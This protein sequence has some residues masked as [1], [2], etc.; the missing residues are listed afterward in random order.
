M[1]VR[2]RA[3]A[4]GRV[5]ARTLRSRGTGARRARTACCSR[6]RSSRPRRSPC[7]CGRHT[8][9]R[10]HT[11]LRGTPCS[12]TARSLCRCTGSTGR[13]QRTGSGRGGGWWL[14][15]C[16]SSAT[17]VARTHAHARVQAPTRT[18]AALTH[19]ST[20]GGSSLSTAAR[21]GSPATLR[22]PP[23][24]TGTPRSRRSECA[25]AR[26]HTHMRQSGTHT[27]APIRARAL[28]PAHSLFVVER[29][30]RPHQAAVRRHLGDHLVP[31]AGE[32]VRRLHHA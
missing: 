6:P 8:G 10:T 2:A 20:P 3:S 23:R 9:C 26:A 31:A 7:S 13:R 32:D 30:N 12:S 29:P 5:R 25:C 1:G 11:R 22:T 4:A 16:T 18:P 21:A 19:S 27:R 28:P 14:S 17:L 15:T 24:S